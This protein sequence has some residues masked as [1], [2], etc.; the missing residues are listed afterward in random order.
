MK[1][2]ISSLLLALGLSQA[3]ASAQTQPD[4]NFHIYLCLGQ[5]NME[6]NAAVTDENREGISDRQ[7]TLCVVD[8]TYSGQ[9]RTAG[10][11]YKA[12]PPLCRPSTGLTPADYCGR[13][14]VDR[15]P[16][17]IRVGFVMVA[18]GGTSIDS[19][20]EDKCEAYYQTAAD[21]LQS[22]LD[23]YGRHP[24]RRLVEMAKVA[25]Q[26]GVIKGIL[27]HQGETN[28]GQADW[29][30][31]VKLVYDR[32]LADLGLEAADVP[33]F[34]GE[35]LSKEQGGICWAHN[36]V[37]GQL[38]SVIPGTQIVSS[39]GCEGNGVDGLHFSNKGYQTLGRHF[40]EAISRTVYG[41]TDERP[42]TAPA[43]E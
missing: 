40:G 7:Q 1:K 15:L 22:F 27:L 26:K 8:G 3:P 42:A 25:Q 13:Y 6:G 36:A 12:V 33:L 21:W 35:T 5:S 24:Y 11:W 34:A 37:I 9:P 16:D 39:A 41:L 31:R 38:P 17:S 43:S 19:F 14:L 30:Q 32:L 29:P 20:D 28:N 4:P 23:A 10:Q 18:I 2:I